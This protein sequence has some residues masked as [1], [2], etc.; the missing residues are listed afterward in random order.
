M[1]TSILVLA[2]G[3][4]AC[5]GPFS[6]PVPVASV[7]ISPAAA[8][9]AQGDSLQLTAAVRD[10]AG[11]TLTDRTVFWSS[12]DPTRILVSAAGLVT[13]L[14]AGAATVTAR[15]EDASD[16]AR[17]R[18]V[19]RVA[20]VV[21]PQ[22]DLTLVPGGA[23]PFAAIAYDPAGN[24]LAGRATT[25]TSG[26]TAVLPV[27]SD[28]VA[29]AAR[30]GTTTL[31]ATVGG[32]SAHVTVQVAR[33]RFTAVSASE[34]RHTCA[35]ATNGRFSC[36]GENG[37]GQL[38]IAA[39]ATASA[40]LAAAG[41]PPVAEVSGGGTFT[42]ARTDGGQVDCWGSGAR[43]RLGT[44]SPTTSPKPTAV[45]L[46]VPLRSLSSGWNH[47]CGIGPD[48]GGTCWGEFPQ[49]GNE[50]GPIAWTPVTVLGD[51]S[52]LQIA[53][54]EGFTC[55]LTT[56]S[57]AFCWG[58]NYSSRLGVADLPNS[59]EPVAVSGAMRFA[60]VGAGGVH[61]CGLTA[62]GAAW[63]WGD[64][65]M[66]Q[67][68][69]GAAA[70][71]STAQPLAVVGGQVFT[72]I[73]VGSHSS[74]ATDTTGAAYCWGADDAGQL[75]AAATESCHGIPCSRMPIAVAGGLAFS[76]LALGD[77]HSCGLATTRILYCWGLNDRGQLGDG[78]TAD[79]A[80]PVRV[81]GQR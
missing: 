68:G 80:T 54:G 7:S 42:C 81:L 32:V 66:G 57:L 10:S 67:L 41:A 23:L 79:R 70:P 37:L 25:W 53:A 39:V 74:C 69:T 6:F 50:P 65:S 75:G 44:G 21:I 9:L 4:L 63:C 55:G 28:G 1:K 78:T 34:F 24:P 58:A 33:V 73:A 60:S 13:A 14:A 12:S 16:S 20:G 5:E 26:D 77:H 76:Q 46:T 2:L 11:T 48:G 17:I 29:T 31:T 22:G 64:N 15:V 30:E 35:R 43:G 8:D 51:L 52:Y 36:W 49:V 40:P 38:G 72:T 3:L 61:A 71:D 56:D 47:S 19:A 45:P 59:V 27:S 62:S 18:V